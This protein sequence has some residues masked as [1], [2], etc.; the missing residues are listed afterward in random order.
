VCGGDQP[1]ETWTDVQGQTRETWLG[2]IAMAIVVLSQADRID[3]VVSDS[4]RTVQDD[5]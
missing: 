3:P 2:D 5:D 1:N 4:F